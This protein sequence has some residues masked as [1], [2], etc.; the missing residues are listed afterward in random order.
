MLESLQL[1]SLRVARETTA[2]AARNYRPLA[3]IVISRPGRV[4]GRVGMDG[5]VHIQA[6]TKKTVTHRGIDD[7]IQ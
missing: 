1:L 7:R 6:P 4:G 5:C 3:R 2:L